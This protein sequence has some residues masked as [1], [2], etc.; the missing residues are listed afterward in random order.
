MNAGDLKARTKQLAIRVIKMCT[1]LPQN[2]T[3]DV[4]AR[5]L[6]RASTSVGANYRAACR[7]RSQADFVAKMSIV[8]EEADE[9]AYWI[10]L[11]VET[12]QVKAQRVAL[13][14]SEVNESV[15][16]ASASRITARK[17]INRQSTIDNRKSR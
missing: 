7:A 13:L 10:E 14:L 11:L 9:C 1:A 15:A 4:I 6:I 3:S 16:I 5:Q 2:R 17:G 8:E 12:D